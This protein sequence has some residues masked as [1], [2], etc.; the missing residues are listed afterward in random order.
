VD[1]VGA[2]ICLDHLGV[3]KVI[4]APVVLGSGFVKCDH[5][6]LPV[7]APA[8]LEILKD[9][10]V[11]KG[12]IE[13]E[14]TTPTGAAIL[15]STASSF[16]ENLQITPLKIG[17]G[18]GNKTG[19]RPNV[20]RLILGEMDE[21][22]DVAVEMNDILS[23]NIDDMNPENFDHLFDILFENGALDVHITPIIMKKSRPAFQLEVLCETDTASR[24]MELIYIHTT[25]LGIKKNTVEKYALK[26]E[27]VIV[28]TPW[29]NVRCKRSYLH[30]SLLHVKPEHEDC[31]RIAIENNIPIEEI[32]NFIHGQ[33][34]VQ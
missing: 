1:I 30:G 26:R 32:K 34:E 17:Y 10:P 25:T 16:A 2:A 14:A 23:C 5:G 12:E 18:I 13:F 19:E 20:L 6:I 15:A 21:A 29:G 24:L 7:P 8:T 31:K 9:I 3:D 28:E 4:S 27:H 11:K 33:R 22:T